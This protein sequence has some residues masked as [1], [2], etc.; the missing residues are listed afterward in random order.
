MRRAKALVVV[1]TAVVVALAGSA[2]WQ[3]FS[4]TDREVTGGRGV[5]AVLAAAI[6]LPLLVRRRHPL[7]VM[8]VVATAAGIQYELGGGLGQAFFAVLLALYSIGAHAPVPSTLVGPALV[9]LQVAAVDVPRLL[10]GDPIDEVVPAWFVLVGAWG[11]GRWMRHRRVES[12]ELVE[13]AD[14]AERNAAELAAQAVAAERA[15]IGRELHDLVAHSMGVIVVQAQGA[16]R[17]LDRDPDRARSALVAIEATGRGGLGEMRRLVGL[18]NTTSADD[19]AAEDATGSTAPQPDLTQLSTLADQV[20]SAGLPVELD[21][22]GDVRPLP[23]GLELSAYRIIQEALTNTL[24][25][26]GP[27]T[28]T[29]RV[30][31]LPDVLDLE[32]VDTGA[33]TDGSGQGGHGLVGM[34]ERVRLYGGSLETGSAPDGGFVVH[35]RL[36]LS[37]ISA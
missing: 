11:F 25:H 35:A 10:R 7:L 19:Q 2:L 1:E 31:Y 33:G 17:A 14:S 3:V 13:R 34:R 21:V 22:E 18:L 29:V 27:A 20:R 23:A 12:V 37:G 4:W 15:R 9:V 32:V 6:T 8:L 24:K 28:A 36:P 30:R 16:Q 5:H 26:A